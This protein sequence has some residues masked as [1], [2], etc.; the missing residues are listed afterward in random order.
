MAR[1]ARLSVVLLVAML[2]A[3]GCGR[4]RGPGREVASHGPT[5]NTAAATATQ[6]PA[7]VANP[8]VGDTVPVGEAGG[9]VTVS[10]VEANVQA[11][12]LFAPPAGRQYFA[13]QVRG[14]SGP[15]EEGLDLRPEYFSLQL[16]DPTVREAGPG[17][18]ELSG[19]TVPAGGCREGWVTF[20]IPRG[21]EPPSS[22]P[23]ARS[24]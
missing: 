22:S 13:A 17:M 2:L 16:A 3:P 20:T 5:R 8:V 21:Q 18:K 9:S 12:R 14:C 23:T 11:G 24:G 1:I 15:T 6:A 7:P 19:G 4:H 10:A